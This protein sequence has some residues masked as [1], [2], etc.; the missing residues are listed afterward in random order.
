MPDKAKL[1]ASR[2]G[3]DRLSKL[4]NTGL[5]AIK[6]PNLEP[7][8]KDTFRWL[9]EPPGVTRNDLTWVIDGSAMNAR[10]STLATFGFAIV[11]IADNGSL[12]AWG[13]GVPPSWID[14]AAGAEAWALHTAV[15]HSPWIPRVLTDCL[16]LIKTAEQ[17]T[18]AATGSSRQLARTWN[19]IA[20]S[21]PGLVGGLGRQ[22]HAGE[23][24]RRQNQGRHK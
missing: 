14:S 24:S 21:L 16:G 19:M 17:G 4:R 1:A 23:G 3:V 2:I 15:L 13:S 8:Q 5:L 7:L 18:P 6:V 9:S 10:W 11:V 20:H 22:Q 12:V